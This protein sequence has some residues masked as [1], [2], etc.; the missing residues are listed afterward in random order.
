MS[1][2]AALITGLGIA[3]PTGLG[4]AEYWAAT[5][6]GRSALGPLT[7]FDGSRYGVAVAGEITGFDDTMIG[8]RLLT[9]T[10]RTTRLALA[11]AEWALA[12]AGVV[13]GERV[14]YEMGTAI[15]CGAGGFEF[16]QRELEKLWSTGSQH[17]S[18][19]QS[20]AWF[21][22][23]NTGQV[24]IRNGLRGASTVL[25]SEQASGLDSL[26]YARRQ[27]VRE[28]G[29]VLAGGIE[30]SLCPW[31]LTAQ[32]TSRRFSTSADPERA[33][34]PFDPAAT[35][36]VPG[37]GG[38][39]LVVENDTGRD[40]PGYAVVTGWAAT[41][42]GTAEAPSQGLLRAASGALLDA[43][44]EPGDIDVV[45]ADGAGSPALDGTEITALSELFGATGVPVTAPKAAVGRLCAGGSALDV[46]T[47]ALALRHQVIPPTPHTR[48][49]DPRLDLVSGAARP[50]ELRSALVLARGY[51][52]FNSALVLRH[53]D[54]VTL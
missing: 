39:V 12:D 31:G 32:A 14:D 11:A 18:G 28:G 6:A 54:A 9:Q 7:S 43:E 15:S 10:D 40:R 41:L 5:L 48:S 21:Y 19:Y 53:P 38:A 25:V 2:P 4:V 1:G 23:V 42:D 45:F 36:S 44:L 29:L 30:S 3:A 49:V 22:A 13:P 37:E 34:L 26:G 16:G 46:A 8:E 50:T 52:G 27:V 33:Y 24:S 51:G 20:F 17:V 35:G 47:A